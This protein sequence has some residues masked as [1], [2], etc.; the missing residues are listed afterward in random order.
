MPGPLPQR[1]WRGPRA[2]TKCAARPR[3]AAGFEPP[4][5]PLMVQGPRPWP[6]LQTLSRQL[7][8]SGPNWG[9]QG[10]DASE[11]AQLILKKAPG[12]R[13]R[14][15]WLRVPAFT[16]PP[17][18][19]ALGPGSSRGCRNQQRGNPPGAGQTARASPREAHSASGQ[20]PLRPLQ[21]PLN[22]RHPLS[23]PPVR[24]QSRDPASRVRSAPRRAGDGTRP[25]PRPPDQR[26]AC[27]PTA[28]TTPRPAPCSWHGRLG[29]SAHTQTGPQEASGLRYPR[30]PGEARTQRPGAGTEGESQGDLWLGAPEEALGL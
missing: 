9:A 6:Q 20:G 1:A 16:D 21:T 22:Q 24:P 5:G 19:A 25:P 11:R 27:S 13:E 23:V 29:L 18:G 28:H 4:P 12:T 10:G 15:G 8:P 2:R 17:R 3:A 14:P 7:S 26:R 30:S